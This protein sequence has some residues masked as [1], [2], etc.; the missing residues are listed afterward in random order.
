MTYPPA[1]GAYP[2]D[3]NQGQGQEQ[4]PNLFNWQPHDPN[5]EPP[6]QGTPPQDVFGD[7]A[8]Q[9]SPGT[10]PGTP[11]GAPP[12]PPGLG[13]GT[14]SFLDPPP[15]P[16]KGRTGILVGML[17]FV[18]IVATGVTLYFMDVIKLPGGGDD[19]TI[20]TDESPGDDEEPAEAQTPTEVVEGYYAAAAEH[21]ADALL[22]TMC[23]DQVSKLEA[24]TPTEDDWA[25]IWEAVDRTEYEITGEEIVEEESEA[26][27]SIKQTSED[28]EKDVT[29]TLVWEDESWKICDFA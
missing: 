29:A 26:K 12:P 11:P 14:P 25:V 22:A 10:P 15:P 13:G 18:L 16:K 28:V 24:E 2:P 19:T 7:A 5:A 21:D 3:P 27:V 8:Q 1:G 23:A 17:V 4:S 20:T 9:P 6:P